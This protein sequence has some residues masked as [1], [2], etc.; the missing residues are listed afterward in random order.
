MNNSPLYVRKPLIV[1]PT[2]RPSGIALLTAHRKL[3]RPQ[4]QAKPVA[5]VATAI[6]E[7]AKTNPAT[8]T[9]SHKWYL[10]GKSS[11]AHA[12]GKAGKALCGRVL[13]GAVETVPGVKCS[14]CERIANGD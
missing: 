7:T 12:A 2:V 11:K 3:S 14:K 8:P 6:Q 1:K 13:T 4:A 10:V 5:N 9:T